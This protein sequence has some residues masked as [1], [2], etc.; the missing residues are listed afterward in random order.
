M[1]GFIAAGVSPVGSKDA[2]PLGPSR[3]PVLEEHLARLYNT[4]AP[5]KS[6]FRGCTTNPPLSWQAVQSDLPF[7]ET[8]VDEAR[9]P[10]PALTL[11]E[12]VWL[13]YKEVVKR[14]AEMYLP[15]HL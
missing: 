9:R 11:Q 2:R 4:E 6:V 7:W 1:V 8:W 14:G 10:N 15:I 13:T 5:L 3:K 12:L